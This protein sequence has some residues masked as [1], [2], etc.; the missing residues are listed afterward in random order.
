LHAETRQLMG[1]DG[2]CDR[3]RDAR[4]NDPENE[5]CVTLWKSCHVIPG[6]VASS[7]FKDRTTFATAADSRSAFV[8]FQRHPR[9][10]GDPRPFLIAGICIHRTYGCDR[11]LG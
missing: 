3:R 4:L 7:Q 2:R 8:I 9:E 5:G 1:G 11:R 10:G 6:V